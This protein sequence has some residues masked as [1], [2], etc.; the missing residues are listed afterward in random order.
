MTAQGQISIEISSCLFRFNFRVLELKN[1]ATRVVRVVCAALMTAAWRAL[2]A[3]TALLVG[4]RRLLVSLLSVN[5][6]GRRRRAAG[7]PR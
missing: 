3:L 7:A 6:D 4:T 5:R 1:K 2:Q